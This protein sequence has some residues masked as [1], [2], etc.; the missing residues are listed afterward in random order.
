MSRNLEKRL[1]RVEQKLADIE[2]KKALAHCI[3][4]GLTIVY[5]KEEENAER[6]RKC[7][8]H[9]CRQDHFVRYSFVDENGQEMTAEDGLRGRPEVGKPCNLSDLYK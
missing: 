5:S 4:K 3:C 7:P 6:N 1:A 9:E 8:V 2:M